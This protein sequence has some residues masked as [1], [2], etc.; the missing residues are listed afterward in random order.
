MMG[1]ATTESEIA[2]GI[3]E[4]RKLGVLGYWEKQVIS[5]L[6]IDIRAI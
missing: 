1:S 3:F 4:Q 6:G 2:R 5:W